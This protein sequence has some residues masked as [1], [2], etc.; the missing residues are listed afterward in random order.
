GWRN[1]TEYTAFGHTCLTTNINKGYRSA[2]MSGMGLAGVG[3]QHHLCITMISGDKT[4]SANLLQRINNTSNTM[5]NSFNGFN[6]RAHHT[7]VA[8]HVAIRVVTNNHIK[9][10]AVY[11]VNQFVSQLC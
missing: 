9:I 11:S 1:I 3:V 7:S 2:G 10:S 4:F 5:V 6:C 8:Y